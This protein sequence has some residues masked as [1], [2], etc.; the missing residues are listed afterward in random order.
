MSENEH[1]EEYD[2]DS[3]DDDGYELDSSSPFIETMALLNDGLGILNALLSRRHS[4]MIL[5]LH[6]AGNSIHV[7]AGMRTNTD[8]TQLVTIKTYDSRISYSNWKPQ[9]IV[10]DIIQSAI[11]C[12]NR[13][14]LEEFLKPD[15]FPPAALDPLNTDAHVSLGV[16]YTNGVPNRWY[17]ACKTGTLYVYRYESNKCI[18]EFSIVDLLSYETTMKAAQTYDDALVSTALCLI[19]TND[20]ISSLS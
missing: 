20:Y 8:M 9:N 14:V 18:H 2:E 4:D 10:G 3:N 7:V 15:R 6:I 1:I 11:V 12:R 13:A 19:R 16:Y 5:S 17:V